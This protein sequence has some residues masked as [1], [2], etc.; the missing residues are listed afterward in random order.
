MFPPEFDYHRAE[1]VEGALDLLAAHADRDP[2]VIAGGQGLVQSM[3]LGAASPGVIVDVAGLDLDWIEADG[4]GVTVGALATHADVVDSAAVRERA[5][6][7]ATAAEAVADLQVRNRGTVGGNLA[8][9]DP[10]ADLP[11]AVLAADATI[12][13]R[14]R[15]GERAIPAEAFFLGEGE[16]AL[17]DDELLTAVRL[18]AGADGA[19]YVRKT[20]PATGYAMVGVAAEVAVA[21]GEVA[22][23]RV[24]ATGATER[25]LRLPDVEDALVGAPVDDEEAAVAAAEQAGDALDA[26]QF[27]GDAHASGEFRAQLLE[28]YTERALE[29][30]LERADGSDGGE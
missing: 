23:A 5:P 13:A 8:E 7:L 6:I 9:A 25:A 24:A 20:H 4:D 10:A 3:K 29:T 1:D 26:D 12:R 30:A 16:T 11:A 21:D 28:A 27:V 15:D 2:A 22:E 19:A 14:G 18:P 17:A